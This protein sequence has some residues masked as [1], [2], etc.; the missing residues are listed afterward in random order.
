M[1][2]KTP[3]TVWNQ[4][5]VT[6]NSAKFYYWEEREKLLNINLQSGIGISSGSQIKSNCFELPNPSCKRWLFQSLSY[7]F[8]HFLINSGWIIYSRRHCFSNPFKDFSSTVFSVLRNFY[9]VSAVKFLLLRSGFHRT[10]W[11]RNL[12]TFTKSLSISEPSPLQ[13]FRVL[14]SWSPTPRLFNTFFGVF[15]FSTTTPEFFYPSGVFDFSTIPPEVFY[16]SGVS[17]F[18]A[19]NPFPIRSDRWLTGELTKHNI[20]WKRG[21]CKWAWYGEVGKWWMKKT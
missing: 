3:P 10:A 13:R 1:G 12:L 4:T 5:A 18:K 6:V 8:S 7:D 2:Q 16:P 19:T 9:R 17:D 21:F 11:F 14:T 20:G 15:D